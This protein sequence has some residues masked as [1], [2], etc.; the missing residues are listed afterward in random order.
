[1]KKTNPIIK[2]AMRLSLRN[3]ND[4]NPNWTELP[5]PEMSELMRKVY[6]QLPRQYR[7]AIKQTYGE[8]KR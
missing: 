8:G 5:E 4:R 3:L 1:M 6:R 7:R 2:E